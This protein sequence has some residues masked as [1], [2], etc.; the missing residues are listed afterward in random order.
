MITYLSQRDSRWAQNK[1]GLSSLTVGRYGC[2]TT[3]I[4]MGLSAFNQKMMPNQLAAVPENYTKDGLI[5][6]QNLKLP[7]NFK[8]KKRVQGR[9]DAAIQS[10]L[11]DPNEFVV[12]QVNN[13]QHWVLAL[14]KTFFGNDYNVA[15]PWWG[16][17]RKACKDYKNITGSSHFSRL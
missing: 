11:K 16:D 15:D 5:V 3:A 9:V 14:S 10:S 6:W 7:G 13:G 12:L 17:K 2:T 4:C 1:L 8:F